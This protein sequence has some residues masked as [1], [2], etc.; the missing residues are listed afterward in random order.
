MNPLTKAVYILRYLGPRIVGLR[1]G[2]YWDRLTGHSRKIFTPRP[3]E[4]IA[5]S[6]IVRPRT[7]GDSVE[8]A[9]FKRESPPPF[10]F[11]LGAPPAI[12]RAV[13]EA[14]CGDAVPADGGRR[15]SEGGVLSLRDRIGLLQQDRCVYGFRRVAPRPIDWYENSLFDKRGRGDRAWNELPDF[16]PA[17][18]D[19]RT[20]WEPARAA[21]A[22]DFARAR[23]R[24]NT[25]AKIV[26]LRELYWRWVDSWMNACP[27]WQGSQWKCG[28][29]SSVRL[30][31]LTLGFWALADDQSDSAARWTQFAR[32][33]WATGYRVAHHIS[34]AVS[35]KNNHALSEALGL[36]LVAHL[37]PEFRD[38]E[39]WGATGRSV[40]ERELRRQIYA[41]GSYVQ[42]SFNYERVMLNVATFAVRLAELAGRPFP[43]D[44]YESLGRCAEFMLE[45]SDPATGR[46]PNYGNNDGAWVLPLSE[47]DFTDFRS[48][49][50]GAY[51]TAHR[52]TPL[53]HGPWDEDLVWLFGS[54]ALPTSTGE[55]RDAVRSEDS[56][57]F[58][59]SP[60]PRAQA[61][62]AHARSAAGR[63]FEAGG[64]YTLRLGESWMMTRCHTYRDRPAHCDALHVD[65]WHRGRNVLIDAGTYQYYTPET[66]ALERFF[67]STRAHNT[68]EIDG[69]DPLELASRYLWLPWPTARTLAFEPPG[70]TR[71]YGCFEGEHRSYARLPGGCV[72]RRAVVALPGDVWVVVDDVFGTGEHTATLRWHAPDGPHHWDASAGRW[73]LGSSDDSPA[74]FVQGFGAALR[75]EVIRHC[76]T[77]E[78]VQGV[79]APY[80]AE[81]QPALC[82][83]TTA[84]GPLPLRLITLVRLGRAHEFEMSDSLVE[85]SLPDCDWRVELAPAD[86]VSDRAVRSI[87]AAPV[88]R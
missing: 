83:E 64:Y 50:Q 20:L 13:R 1:A 24:T 21:W 36:M 62:G 5:L 81:L 66:P 37:F 18:G 52:K 65:L 11:P 87:A 9:A 77:P 60:A 59:S 71:A 2:V 35:Q 27:P 45:M 42:Q 51:F 10:L 40:M 29:E 70:D 80:Y 86:G 88:V 22:I 17:Q 43:R 69:R 26:E 61:T 84:R 3:W 72:H 58:E 30:V 12:P 8:Y 31:A 49:I 63:A 23:A 68:V 82:L 33:A 67:K 34:Y 75:S 56:D 41:D 54:D 48:A 85:V 6:D 46:M 32:L 16:A 55:L 78:R 15:S 4:S 19:V 25:N 7:P 14:G 76:V 28:Q 53:P 74:L 38:S 57:T 47:I 44:I 73:T 39:A 79:A